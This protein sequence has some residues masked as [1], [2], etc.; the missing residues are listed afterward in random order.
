MYFI[1]ACCAGSMPGDG[2][3]NRACQNIVTPMSSG[4]GLMGKLSPGNMNT[5]SGFDRSQAHKNGFPR[6]SMAFG[7]IWNNAKKIGSWISIGQQPLMGL[8][9]CSFQ[10]SIVFLF[11]FIGSSLYFSWI[12]FISGAS[13]AMRFIDRVLFCVSGQKRSLMMM[14]MMMSAMAYL[15]SLSGTIGATTP[16]IAFIARSISLEMGLKKPK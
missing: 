2:G 3:C 4:S 14:V 15:P 9:L 6:S 12:F 16:W 7:I 1:M 8:T 5:L 13:A 11:I 10:N